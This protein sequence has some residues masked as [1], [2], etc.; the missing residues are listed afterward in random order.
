MRYRYLLGVKRRA[1]S[2]FRL[3]R[4]A[5]EAGID[6]ILS[7]SSPQDLGTNLGT[8]QGET[9]VNQCDLAEPVRLLKQ[10]T[11]TFETGRTPEKLRVLSA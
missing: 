2:A 8:K 1:S 4:Q 6:R 10:L 3:G 9:A 5:G 7:G 11:C